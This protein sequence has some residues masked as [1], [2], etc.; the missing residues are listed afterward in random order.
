MLTGEDGG[1]DDDAA[2]KDS[3]EDGRRTRI[4]RVLVELT[5]ST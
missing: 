3:A 1:E 5:G 4:N 2:V